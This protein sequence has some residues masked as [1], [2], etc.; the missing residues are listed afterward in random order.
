[1]SPHTHHSFGLSSSLI[2]SSLLGQ[3]E[4]SV[5]CLPYHSFSGCSSLR[6]NNNYIACWLLSGFSGAHPLSVSGTVEE[7]GRRS[8]VGQGNPRKEKQWDNREDIVLWQLAGFPISSSRQCENQ[9]D[10][11]LRGLGHCKPMLQQRRWKC[12]HRSKPSQFLICVNAKMQPLTF[13]EILFK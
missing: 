1:M 2:T 12:S 7:A 10:S 4:S 6:Q 8:P 3:T 11:L 13:G 9:R 5:G